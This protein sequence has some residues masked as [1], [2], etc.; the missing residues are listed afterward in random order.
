MRGASNGETDREAM[1]AGRDGAGVHVV[2]EVGTTNA[3][4][5]RCRGSKRDSGSTC[6][7]PCDGSASDGALLR[8]RGSTV[9]RADSDRSASSVADRSPERCTR[10][11]A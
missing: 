7:A 5:G 6:E 10:A 3:K 11:V 9:R 2:A 8:E 1:L 4:S